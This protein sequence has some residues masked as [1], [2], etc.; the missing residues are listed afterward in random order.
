MRV[1]DL[2]H[3]IESTMPVYPGTEPPT[4]EPANTYE[5]DGFKETRISMFTHTG[6]H[7]G[8]PAHLFRDRTALDAFP[9]D[10]FIGKAL[11]VDCTSLNEGEP[12][13]MDYLLPYGEKTK[14]AGVQGNT[15]AITRALMI[16][17]WITFLMATIKG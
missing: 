8:P 15:L 5:K 9:P 16:A 11:V 10:Q 4:F 7:M 2:T 6:T 3:V 14:D 13:T 12:I 1:V 17:F